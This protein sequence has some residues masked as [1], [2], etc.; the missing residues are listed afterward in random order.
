MRKINDQQELN[1]ILQRKVGFLRNA[2]TTAMASTWH[3]LA[4]LRP[5]PG[6]CGTTI[7]V[8]KPRGKQGY[9]KYFAATEKEI[10]DNEKRCRWCWPDLA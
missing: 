5:Q 7:M 4:K 3:N 2:G 10:P 8:V 6:F 9:D 1:L